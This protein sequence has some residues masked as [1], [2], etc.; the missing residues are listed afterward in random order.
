MKLSE[1]QS[2]MLK[3]LQEGWEL[4][5]DTNTSGHTVIYR[6]ARLQKNGL[7]HGDPIEYFKV[8]VVDA[9]RRKC[10]IQ[11]VDEPT[12]PMIKPVRYVLTQAGKGYKIDES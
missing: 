2:K 6:T 3:L 7:G 1:Q 12:Y 8:T 9:L 10:L 5:V 4:G 11:Q